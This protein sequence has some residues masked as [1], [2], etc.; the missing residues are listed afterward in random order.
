MARSQTQQTPPPPKRRFSIPSPQEIFRSLRAN[1]PQVARKG[2]EK[3]RQLEAEAASQPISAW[4]VI[5][6]LLPIWVLLIVILIL[7]PALPLKAVESL[8]RFVSRIGRF[9]AA[10]VTSEPV[11][12]VQGATAVAIQAS[13]PPPSWILEISPIFTPEV[14]HWKDSML[15]WSTTYRVKPNLIATLVQ[16]ESCG[17]PQAVSGA[18]A[19]GLFQVLPGNFQAGD[20]PFD[21]ETN[22]RVGLTYFAQMLAAANGDVGMAFAAYNGGPS[23]FYSSPTEWPKETQSYQYWGSGIVEETEMGLDQSP[24]LQEWLDSGGA[25]LCTQAHQTLGLP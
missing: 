12:I 16:I 8:G 19:Q 18:N 1:R 4:Q 20:N 22:A 13:A 14:Q 3:A 2:S 5:V 6:G 9:P 7:E 15:V 23:V 24:T 25:S 17:N 21:V 10:E 11:F